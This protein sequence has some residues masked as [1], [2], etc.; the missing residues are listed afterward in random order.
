MLL[1]YN[2]IEISTGAPGRAWN[3]KNRGIPLQKEKTG[4]PVIVAVSQ[5][6]CCG[7]YDISPLLVTGSLYRPVDLAFNIFPVVTLALVI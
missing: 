1:I 3:Q 2:F 6:E 5:K 4:S 7:L